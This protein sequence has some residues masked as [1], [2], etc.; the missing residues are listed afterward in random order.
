MSS[1]NSSFQLPP[2]SN[3]PSYEYHPGSPERASLDAALDKMKSM[4]PFEVPLVLNGKEVRPGSPPL[5]HLAADVW[6]VL[7]PPTFRSRPARH[8]LS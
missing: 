6:A 2:V 1:S 3:Q 5:L 4:M 7:L 8:F